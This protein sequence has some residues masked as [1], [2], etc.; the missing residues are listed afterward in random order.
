MRG[1]RHFDLVEGFRGFSSAGGERK[2]VSTST[3]TGNT[4]TW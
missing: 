1:A 4:L 2:T 3:L